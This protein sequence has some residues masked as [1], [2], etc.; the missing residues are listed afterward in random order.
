MRTAQPLLL[1]ATLPRAVVHCVYDVLLRHTRYPAVL[2]RGDDLQQ[3]GDQ[4][5]DDAN[6]LRGGEVNKV[7]L[8]ARTA[9]ISVG[10]ASVAIAITGRSITAASLSAQHTMLPILSV[11]IAAYPPGTLTSV[12][13]TKPSGRRIAKQQNMLIKILRRIRNRRFITLL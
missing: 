8:P 11:S 2:V 3:L 6:H 1:F 13:A 10:W 9:I 12:P 7:S 5:L 4:T